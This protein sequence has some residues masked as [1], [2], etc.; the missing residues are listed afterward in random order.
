METGCYP[1][2]NRYTSASKEVCRWSKDV[3]K[4]RLDSGRGC[5]LFNQRKCETC[6]W[7]GTKLFC[8]GQ[9]ATDC[10]QFLQKGGAHGLPF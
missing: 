8:N 1:C 5:L 2:G 4:V 9:K 6:E 3:I 10:A 7:F